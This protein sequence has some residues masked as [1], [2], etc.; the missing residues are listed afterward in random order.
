MSDYLN[1]YKY[2]RGERGFFPGKGWE[3]QRVVAGP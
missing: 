3:D 2:N 1:R